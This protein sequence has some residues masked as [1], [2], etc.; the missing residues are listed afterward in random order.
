MTIEELA[1]SYYELAKQNKWEEIIDRYYDDDIECIEPANSKS[2]PY[3]KGKQNVKAKAMHFQ[4]IIEVFHDGYVTEPI[5]A[6]DLFSVGMGMEF[7]MKGSGRVRFDEIAVFRV[8]DGKVI[9]EEFIMTWSQGA[10]HVY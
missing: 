10:G 4:E 8:K 3:T 1:R 7:T 5:V 9:R 2:A 6:G